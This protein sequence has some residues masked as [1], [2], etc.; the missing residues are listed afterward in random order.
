MA[1]LRARREDL[2]QAI[3]ARVHYLF[4]TR[5]RTG[6]YYLDFFGDG[7]RFHGNPSDYEW[8]EKTF[9][10]SEVEDVRW[11]L[12]EEFHYFGHTAEEDDNHEDALRPWLEDDA[13]VCHFLEQLKRKYDSNDAVYP[14]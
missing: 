2:R 5:P 10:I 6:D 12:I 11:Q 13:A 7:T 3:E 8:L 4:G 9:G 14:G 1:N